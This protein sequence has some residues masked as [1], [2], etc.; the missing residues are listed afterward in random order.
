MNKEL[1]IIRPPQLVN[2]RL[3]VN[4]PNL[5]EYF[6]SIHGQQYSNR[7]KGHSRLLNSIRISLQP[8]FLASFSSAFTKNYKKRKLKQNHWK[9]YFYRLS[10][11]QAASNPKLFEIHNTWINGSCELSIVALGLKT[12][13]WIMFVF[14]SRRMWPYDKCICKSTLESAFEKNQNLKLDFLNNL[15]QSWLTTTHVA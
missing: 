5:C 9:K 1:N 2:Q 6:V 8:T 14:F 15:S 11:A 3:G 4:Q 10:V 12:L 13:S 7:K